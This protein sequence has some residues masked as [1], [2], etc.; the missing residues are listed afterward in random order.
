[1]FELSP[2]QAGVAGEYLVAGELSRR[3][4]LASLTLRNSE[5]I[6]VLAASA[7]ASRSVGIQVKTT[8]GS[9]GR[10]L[11]GRKFEKFCSDNL[12][13]VFVSLHHGEQPPTFHVVPSHVLVDRV[14]ARVEWWMSTTD[15]QGQPHKDSGI[16]DFRDKDGDFLNKWELLGLN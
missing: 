9:D 11:V 12:F 1:M 4:Y 8:R 14:R 7:D 5:G 6:D 2:T 13:Y 16:R 15:R 3:G 10:W